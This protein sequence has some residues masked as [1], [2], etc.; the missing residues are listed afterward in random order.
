MK[1]DKKLKQYITYV[2]LATLLQ[3]VIFTL[4]HYFTS[5][6]IFDNNY[7]IVIISIINGF[8]F[9]RKAASLEKNN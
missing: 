2:L 5:F 3:G 8:L 4:I 6:K 1:N 9:T 7:F